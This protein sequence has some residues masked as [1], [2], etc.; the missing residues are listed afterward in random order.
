MHIKREV[1]FL[2]SFNVGFIGVG[3]MGGAILNGM[4]DKKLIDASNIYLYD[5]KTEVL[6]KFI[7]AGRDLS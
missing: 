7:K 5:Y 3:N 2:N 1:I 4:L 6:D